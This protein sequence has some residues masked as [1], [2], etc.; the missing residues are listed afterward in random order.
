LTF[1]KGTRTLLFAIECCE[2]PKFITP[3]LAYEVPLGKN[4]KNIEPV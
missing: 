1:E 3:P 4:H 2:L